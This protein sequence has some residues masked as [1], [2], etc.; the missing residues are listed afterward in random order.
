MQKT[1]VSPTDAKITLTEI[2]RAAAELYR[3]TEK[4]TLLKIVHQVAVQTIKATDTIQKEIEG[5]SGDA[6]L[7]VLE[8]SKSALYLEDMVDADTM[9]EFEFIVLPF[10]KNLEN[11]DLICFLSEITDKVEAKYNAML[12]KIHEFNALF[13]D[14]LE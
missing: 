4:L 14:E 1:V 8:S 13:K 9:S 11:A 6:L 2:R 7:D 5:L 10:V 12:S 3:F